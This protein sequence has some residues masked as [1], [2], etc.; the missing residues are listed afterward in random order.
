MEW[1]F[2]FCVAGKYFRDTFL[3]YVAFEVECH[4]CRFF[5][6]LS[7]V[8]VVLLSGEPEKT[9]KISEK[10]CLRNVKALRLVQMEA[11]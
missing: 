10:D 4:C 9:G 3:W 5:V 2:I 11:G 6:G 8:S 7:L 1:K